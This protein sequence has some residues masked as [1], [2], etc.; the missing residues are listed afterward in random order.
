M[1]PSIPRCYVDNY[2]YPPFIKRSAPDTLRVQWLTA[3]NRSLWTA[4]RGE[5]DGSSGLSV[6]DDFIK[7]AM[8]F[9]YVLP[10]CGAVKITL[11]VDTALCAGSFAF[12]LLRSNCNVSVGSCLFYTSRF[13][14]S[15]L[16]GHWWKDG[17]PAAKCTLSH[18]AE[19]IKSPYWRRGRGRASEIN[20]ARGYSRLQLV[21]TSTFSHVI[22]VRWYTALLNM[23]SI[24]RYLW[25]T[26]R[27]RC[28]NHASSL[29]EKSKLFVHARLIRMLLN[30]VNGSMFKQTKPNKKQN[31]TK[32]RLR[33]GCFKYMSKI[34]K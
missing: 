17:K 11:E 19:P 24:T 8:D 4:R 28:K 2:I 26:P 32:K 12:D 5:T 3:W 27:T 7:T 31:K 9:Y 30:G 16:N 20:T 23:T 22:Y 18:T 6:C 10:D 1:K 15:P 21:K 34:N 25:T 29:C 13:Y 33:T 14:A